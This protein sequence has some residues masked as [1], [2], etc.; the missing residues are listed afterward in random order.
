MTTPAA[1]PANNTAASPPKPTTPATPHDPHFWGVH[2]PHTA[3]PP[4]PDPKT[5][6]IAQRRR[7][8]ASI[9][10]Q[11]IKERDAHRREW[12]VDLEHDETYEEACTPAFLGLK[13]EH[14]RPGDIVRFVGFER[15]FI[16]DRLVIRN[17]EVLR[18]V[19]T[20][21]IAKYDLADRIAGATKFDFSV[22]T[23]EEVSV[24][25]GSSSWRVVSGHHIVH[26]K[27]PSK[28][29]AAKWLAQRQ[30]EPVVA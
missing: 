8:S 25:G 12:A 2:D 22:C 4:G 18:S 15:S 21:E 27:F 26:D 13:A 10:R 16:A 5:T 20:V 23:I 11:R 19:W 1:K 17:D 7:S 24:S 30:S 6:T 9:H 28:A 14:L 3:K 29:H